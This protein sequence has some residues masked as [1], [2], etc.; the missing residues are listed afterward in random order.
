MAGLGGDTLTLT[1]L[2][3]A[4]AAV[5]VFV[6][7]ARLVA[8]TVTVPGTGN[9]CGAVKVA[10]IPAPVIV[11]TV[12]LPPGMFPIL[13]LTPALGALDTV[14]ESVAV[15]VTV[16]PNSTDEFAGARTIEIP[17]GTGCEAAGAWL[18][19]PPPHPALDARI[20]S[21]NQ[22][23][24]ITFLRTPWF[25]QQLAIR[26]VVQGACQASRRARIS[27]PRRSAAYAPAASTPINSANL[28]SYPD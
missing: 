16:F 8:S 26:L 2:V 23:A 25:S 14:F 19:T 21:A 3:I 17:F 27:A 7:S 1:S 28:V 22:L 11:P 20:T 15:S 13:Q 12:V 5:A 9:D 18:V 10:V 6:G 4:I 24:A